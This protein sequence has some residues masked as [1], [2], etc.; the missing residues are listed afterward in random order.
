[1]PFLVQEISRLASE[2]ASLAKQV[3]KLAGRVSG[4]E[5]DKTDLSAQLANLRNES[6][7]FSPSQNK[8]LLPVFRGKIHVI[9]KKKG[10]RTKIC[11]QYFFAFSIAPF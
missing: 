7:L 1:M 8:L 5:A 9:T 6:L 2:N 11:F 10:Q 4:L 3:A